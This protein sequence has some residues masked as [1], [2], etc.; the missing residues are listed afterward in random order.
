MFFLFF[1]SFLLSSSFCFLLEDAGTIFN[2]PFA[3]FICNTELEFFLPFFSRLEDEKQNL[4]RLEDFAHK[5][6]ES[7]GR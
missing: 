6:L 7:H 1:S 4:R 2:V 5:V 3:L